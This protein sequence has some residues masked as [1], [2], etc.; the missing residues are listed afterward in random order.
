MAE[1]RMRIEFD[2]P[3]HWGQ[4]FA[5][6]IERRVS[7]AIEDKITASINREFISIREAS[8]NLRATLGS[9]GTL[10]QSYTA[11]YRKLIEEVKK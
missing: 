11:E 3:E 1:N 7:Q 2:F 8:S 10:L 9:L 6:N 5:D 4:Y